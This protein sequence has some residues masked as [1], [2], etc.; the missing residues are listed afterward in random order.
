M[1]LKKVTHLLYA[2]PQDM[3]GLPIRQPFPTVVVDQIDP[4]LLFHHA[5]VKVP[6]H[7]EP[8]HAGVGPHPHRGFS[9]V[10]FIFEGGVH[11]RDSRGN[12]AVVYAPGAQWMNAGMGVIHSERP[13]H[14]IHERSGYQEIVQ[15][16][17]N[18]P[19]SNKMDQPT[20]FPVATE[21]MPMME[22]ADGKS[23]LRL[24]SG[25][26]MS[27]KGPVKTT[28]NVV[29]AMID[30]ESGGKLEIPV[31]PGHNS[32]VYILKGSISVTGYGLAEQHNAVVFDKPGDA[33]EFTAIE[34]STLLFLSGEPIGEKVVQHGPF[35]MNNQTQILE[36]M[37]DYQMGKMGM[38][39]EE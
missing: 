7:L 24:V 17:V 15:L 12:N 18:T 33:I 34:K 39:I 11:H 2:H 20:Y 14:D 5:R 1:N 29:S 23:V 9:P 8:R 37:R 26:L 25:E 10:T 32:L 35:V 4:F 3:G 6:S 22:G 31:A 38:L 21:D 27:R 36:A 13:P 16:W 19:A 30:I 28:V